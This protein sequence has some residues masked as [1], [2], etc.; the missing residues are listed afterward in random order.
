MVIPTVAQ[1]LTMT[2]LNVVLLG[3]FVSIILFTYRLLSF[4]KLG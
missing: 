1:S 2:I 4:F 3:L